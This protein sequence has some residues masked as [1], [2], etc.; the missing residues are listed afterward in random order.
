MLV[1]KLRALGT[2]RPGIAYVL[3][4]ALYLQPTANSPAARTMRSVRGHYFEHPKNGTY[5]N[6]DPKRFASRSVAPLPSSRESRLPSSAEA[7]GFQPLPDGQAEPTAAELAALVVEFFVAAADD[8]NGKVVF[9]GNGDPLEAADTVID[10]VRRVAQ[11]RDGVDF[12]L[13]TLGL[14]DSATVDRLLSST[15]FAGGSRISAVSVFL[16][17]AESSMYAQLLRPCDGRGFEQVCEF[18]QRSAAA[19]IDVEVTAVDR[20]D[21]DV[22][23]VEALALRLGASSFRRR[24]WVGRGSA[25]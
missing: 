12:R 2:Y 15:A 21:V 17:A 20:P 4:N 14:C 5:A 10:T 23:E 1:E 24:S 11:E 25:L 9:Q 7:T 13:N 16:P 22:H 8:A 3:S 18:V 19:G 6:L